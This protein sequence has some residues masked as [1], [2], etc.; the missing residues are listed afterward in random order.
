VRPA[1]GEDGEEVLG[2]ERDGERVGGR[3]G[4]AVE[5]E[6]GRAGDRRRRGRSGCRR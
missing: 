5:E 3:E 2:V 4:L 1:G 6:S